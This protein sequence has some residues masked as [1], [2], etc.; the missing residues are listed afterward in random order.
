MN[1]KLKKHGLI[2]LKMAA[3]VA[4]LGISLAGVTSCS[5]ANDIFVIE[6]GVITGLTEEGRQQSDLVIPDTFKGVTI[7]RIGER[8]FENNMILRSVKLSKSLTI[9]ENVFYGCENI[10]IVVENNTTSAVLEGGGNLYLNFQ[11]Q[12]KGV[13]SNGLDLKLDDFNFNSTSGKSAISSSATG[14]IRIYSDGLEN[15]IRALGGQF[16]INA[17]NANI[18]VDGPGVLTIKGGD[19]LAEQVGGVGIK[20]RQLVLKN[21]ATLSVAGGKGGKG[22]AGSNGGMGENGGAGSD[23]GKGGTAIDVKTLNAS[24]GT[25]TAT[26]GNGGDGGNGGQ[27]GKC[28]TGEMG[29][30]SLSSGVQFDGKKGGKGGRGGNGGQGGEAGT[31]VIAENVVAEDNIIEKNG[32]TGNGGNGGNGGEGGNGGSGDTGGTIFIEQPYGLNGGDG[33]DGGDGGNGGRGFV[34]G[35]AGAGG[36]GGSGGAGITKSFGL[37][38]QYSK[39]G[40]TGNT[41]EAGNPGNPGTSLNY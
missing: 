36:V 12:I 27:G 32:R 24:G 11:I 23:G 33:G 6:E 35:E 2:I 17:P 13:G 39:T 1:T 19:S 37:F 30:L 31:A 29:T 21:M 25:I 3:F 7:T 15:N 10:T 26:A 28:I 22:N 14:T 8:A 4:C 38:Q 41:G 34:G 18:E 40:V 5:Q 20:A 16:G 9:S